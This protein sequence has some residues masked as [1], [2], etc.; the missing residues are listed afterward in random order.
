MAR[1]SS[2]RPT[3]SSRADRDGRDP[4][5]PIEDA[6]IV[7]EVGPEGEARPDRADAEGE[8]VRDEAA[9]PHDGHGPGTSEVE[10]TPDAPPD[11]TFDADG[12]VSSV[13]AA[14]ETP[15]GMDGD[16]S[17]P[18]HGLGAGDET[19]AD[20][21]SGILPTRDLEG[22]AR[23]DDA[24][25]A[26]PL[27][28]P[29][30]DDHDDAPRADDDGALRADDDDAP[31]ADDAAL[32]PA[33][34]VD[35]VG[36]P[37][38]PPPPEEPEPTAA[39]APDVIEVPPSEDQ[40]GRDRDGAY[41][42]A[43]TGAATGA[44][45]ATGGAATGADPASAR[46]DPDPQPRRGGLG[47]MVL[48]GL[49]AGAIG[50]AAAW[51]LGQGP[52]EAAIAEGEALAERVALLEA[53]VDPDLS[54][55]ESRIG[56]IEGAIPDTAPIDARLAAVEGALGD[57]ADTAT[58]EAL[59]E[60]LSALEGGLASLSEGAPAPPSAPAVT[61]EAVGAVE[62]VTGEN[63]ERLAAIE[64]RLAALPEGLS[65]L[66]G[67]VEGLGSDISGVSGEVGALRSEIED[68]RN[69]LQGEIESVRGAVEEVRGTIQS[70]EE[71]VEAERLALEAAAEEEARALRAE[72]ATTRIRAAIDTGEPLMD[73][74]A[75][76]Q[77]ATE[78]LVPDVLGEV[79]R[80]GVDSLATLQSAFDPA[81]RAA[82]AAAPAEPG[83]TGFLRSQVGLRSLTEREGDGV[84][85]VLSRAQARLNDG[86]LRA[87]IEALDALEGRPSEEMSA[88]LDRART[89]LAAT[90]AAD[91]LTVP[92]GTE[93]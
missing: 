57:V 56:E 32:I 53:R 35:V 83:P 52:R 80:D 79:A 17:D 29:T 69:A 1:R 84:D 85:A 47:A 67:R 82:L 16:P 23:A 73:A 36:P 46:S 33:S 72:A 10:A 2:G 59:G 44:G 88:W 41:A 92:A 78:R 20:D 48:G 81:A 70:R 71:A 34:T 43:A 25:E 74:L 9:A 19:A 14:G 3:G 6:E 54:P 61:A 8:P 7:G 63:A 50:F 12:P 49:L 40:V 26:A 89:R 55:I 31:R 93:G 60:R 65:D 39:D 90:Q 58:L 64:E 45:A 18:P 62:S 77:A 5:E 15:A 21:G 66:P 68:L 30:A 38:A 13:E 37:G 4:S 28:G 27:G 22:D 51:L 42:G 87:A 11:E 75:E 91:G 86:D 76:W 24:A